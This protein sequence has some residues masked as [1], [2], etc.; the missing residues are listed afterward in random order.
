MSKQV[1]VCRGCHWGTLPS[2]HAIQLLIRFWNLPLQKP[3]L[4][5]P[6]KEPLNMHAI[7]SSFTASSR[8]KLDGECGWDCWR[9]RSMVHSWPE[10]KG[11]YV[12]AAGSIRF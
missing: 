8:S 9:H 6:I 3:G 5:L 12:V 7:Y 2:L 1:R 10:Q 4:W 11:P